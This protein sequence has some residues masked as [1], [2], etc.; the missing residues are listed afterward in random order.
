MVCEFFYH[1]YLICILQF[2]TALPTA[3]RILSANEF[4]DGQFTEMQGNSLEAYTIQFAVSG[5]AGVVLS[6]MVEGGSYDKNHFNTAV[7]PLPDTA[8]AVTQLTAEQ[9]SY[10]NNIYMGWLTGLDPL[11]DNTILVKGMY[12][13]VCKS[14]WPSYMF[15]VWGCQQNP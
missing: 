5:Q 11:G 9:Q 12:V 6:G 1:I 13:C 4:K 3:S 14:L 10:L 7:K 2:Y 15:N 8:W